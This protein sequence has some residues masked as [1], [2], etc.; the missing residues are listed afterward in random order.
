MT[1]EELI[2]HAEAKREEAFSNGTVNDL[3]YW[4]GYIDALKAVKGNG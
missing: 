1:V 4:S 3:A 2:K